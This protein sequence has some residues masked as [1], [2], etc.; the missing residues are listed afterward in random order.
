MAVAI[1]ANGTYFLWAAIRQRRHRRENGL[2]VERDG[3][4]VARWTEHPVVDDI[5]TGLRLG[6]C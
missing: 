5:G 4:F 1:A 3:E 2:A 6:H